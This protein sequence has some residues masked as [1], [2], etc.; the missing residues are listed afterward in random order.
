MYT[1]PTEN[2]TPGTTAGRCSVSAL[3]RTCTSSAGIFNTCTHFLLKTGLQVLLLVDVRLVHWIGPVLVQQED[4]IH[5]HI[6]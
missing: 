3:N 6:P 5:V 4:S 1:F 2:W